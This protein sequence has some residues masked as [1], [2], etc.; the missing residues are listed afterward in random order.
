MSAP[1][2][3]IPIVSEAYRAVRR[4]YRR[5]AYAGAEVS[6]P[7]CGGGFAS[8]VGRSPHGIC[9]GCDAAARHRILCLHLG[10]CADV[11]GPGRRLLHFAPEPC[12]TRHFRSVD[13][14]EYTSAD[15]SAPGADVHTDITAQVFPDQSFDAVVCC[16][17]LEHI[18]DDRK[19]MRELFRVLRPGGTLFA[20]VPYRAHEETVEDPSI[21]DPK[22]RARLYGQEDHVRRYGSDFADRLREAGFSVAEERVA[23]T[24]SEEERRRWGVWDDVLF[25]CTRPGA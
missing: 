8:W 13:G 10:Q 15:L 14:L 3:Y 16:H 4:V 11:Y 17:V 25:V 21:R 20:M 6:C 5:R 7:V 18:P 1:Y 2:R 22:E 9:P 23:R 12:L 19:A 24:L